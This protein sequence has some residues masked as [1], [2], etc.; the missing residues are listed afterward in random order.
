VVKSYNINE[1][2]LF[3]NPFAINFEI[4]QFYGS[5]EFIAKFA[6]KFCI[7]LNF[8]IRMLYWILA[9][10]KLGIIILRVFSIIK[11]FLK[12]QEIEVLAKI[13]HLNLTSQNRHFK[14]EIQNDKLNL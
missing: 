2:Y 10:N 14:I 8:I 11:S 1:L 5:F 3:F 4:A 13:S 12:R 6:N 7:S 9:L